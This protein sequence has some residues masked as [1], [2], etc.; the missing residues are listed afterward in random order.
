MT[1][2]NPLT[3]TRK[4][5]EA[6]RRFGRASYIAWNFIIFLISALYMAVL[7]SVYWTDIHAVFNLPSYE[8]TE[9]L[10]L[11]EETIESLN[12]FVALI[13][14]IYLY[15]LFVFSIKRLH[16]LDRSGWLSLLNLIPII[17][18]FFSAWLSIKVGSEGKN[19]FGYPRTTQPWEY[20]VAWASVIIMVIFGLV[21]IGA[22]LMLISKIS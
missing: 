6:D 4:L 1:I 5:Y 12:A 13:N 21:L 9:S 20:T 7:I 17:N 8:T 11:I 22:I 18:L 16:D 10:L 15:F 2:N 14:F 19:Q 3:D